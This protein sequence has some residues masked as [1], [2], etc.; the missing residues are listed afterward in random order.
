MSPVQ[1]NYRPL[2]CHFESNA[3]LCF[4]DESHLANYRTELLGPIVA[5]DSASQGPEA[6][7]VSACEDHSPFVLSF[8]SGGF[9][10]AG[11]VSHFAWHPVRI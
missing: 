6:S 7:T 9:A 5:G 4:F 10:G 8:H 1:D 11:S 2:F 3:S